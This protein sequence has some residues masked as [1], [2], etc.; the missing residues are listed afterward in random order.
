M[1]FNNF[2]NWFLSGALAVASCVGSQSGCL[3]DKVNNKHIPVAVDRKDKL[4]IYETINLLD[5]SKIERVTNNNVVEN[6]WCSLN[7]NLFYA[8]KDSNEIMVVDSSGERKLCETDVAINQY[9]L[10]GVISGDGTKKGIIYGGVG[11]RSGKN[12]MREIFS[13]ICFQPIR[14]EN[15]KVVLNGERQVLVKRG[16]LTYYPKNLDEVEIDILNVNQT[17]GGANVYFTHPVSEKSFCV[18]LGGIVGKIDEISQ[19]SAELERAI[20][21]ERS[22]QIRA[23]KLEEYV[24]K[25]LASFGSSSE[26]VS[27]FRD[28]KMEL[29]H[30]TPKY[31]GEDKK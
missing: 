18:G 31:S 15:G 3:D 16:P 23:G 10:Y 29:Y 8:A 13:E 30:F 14:E 9:G 24:P 22:A 11:C 2:A 4:K 28:G 5:G 25:S 21:F 1:R 17:G 26:Y 12:D 7:G 6:A 19:G 27:L 20:E